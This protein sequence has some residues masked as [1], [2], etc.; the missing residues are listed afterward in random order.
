MSSVQASIIDDLYQA[1]IAVEDQSERTQQQAFSVA[2]RAVLVKVRGNPDLLKHADIKR[3]I[4]NPKPYVRSYRYDIEAAQLFVVINFDQ[5]RVDAAIRDANFPIWDKRRPDTLVWMAI[6]PSMQDNKK[7]ARVADYA[8]IYQQFSDVAKTRGIRLIFP[9]WD[10][11]DL[12][13]LDVYDI[14]GEFSRP[15]KLASERYDVSSILSLRVYPSQASI[16]NTEEGQTSS[17]A[18]PEW[19]ADW[20]MFEA[21]SILS[22]KIQ[23]QSLL[24]LAK[25]MVDILADQ[26]AAKY[27]IDLDQNNQNRQKVEIVINNINSLTLYQQA[28]TMLE[29]LSVVTSATLV[30]QQGNQAIFALDLL[31]EVENLQNA[32]SLD[33][34]IKP[35]VDDFGQPI[36]ELQFFWVK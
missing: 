2:L 16:T 6:Q 29:N 32:L 8:E 5:T 4:N 3:M 31:G 11:D 12:Q 15:I 23:Q 13:N 1:K 17:V 14:W 7:I 10:I 20:T 22:G 25:I 9:L 30:K 27:A 18:L 24:A 36:G 21:S 34:Q 19:T 28:L 26:L 33:N 35:V